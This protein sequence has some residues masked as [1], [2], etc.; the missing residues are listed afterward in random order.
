MGETCR[1]TGAA[2]QPTATRPQCA[3]ASRKLCQE[4]LRAWPHPT[5]PPQCTHVLQ[6]GMARLQQH[7]GIHGQLRVALNL[8]HPAGGPPKAVGGSGAARVLQ[9]SERRQLAAALLLLGCAAAAPGQR[10]A[11]QHNQHCRPKAGLDSRS[12]KRKRSVQHWA[13]RVG[14]AVAAAWQL[15]GGRQR[16]AAA[17]AV[18]GWRRLALCVL[19]TAC[20]GECCRRNQPAVAAAFGRRC[21]GKRA[22][23]VSLRFHRSGADQVLHKVVQK[24][25]TRRVGMRAL[26]GGGYPPV[27]QTRVT[28]AAPL[29]NNPAEFNCRAGQLQWGPCAAQQPMKGHRKTSATVV[30]RR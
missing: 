4:L 10:G 2:I 26:V 7:F 23:P 5:K 8:C 27:S 30:G 18:A 9:Q 14:E 6:N 3:Q 29:S 19:S 20:G 28:V 21:G 15:G 1:R 12:G 16:Q 24:Q 17:A 11:A 13:C 22:G 25:N